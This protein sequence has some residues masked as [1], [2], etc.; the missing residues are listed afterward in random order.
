MT[1]EDAVAAKAELDR[2]VALYREDP[3]FRAMAQSTV[4]LVMGEHGPVDPGRA[5]REAH[6]IALTVAIT[7]LARVYWE[8]AE[9][10]DLR[11]ERDMY[12]QAAEKF[13]NVSP[14]PAFLAPI[15]PGSVRP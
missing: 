4:S 12:K 3:R 7:M 5:D 11:R 14:L 8:D 10:A 13:I 9:I 2:A 15:S 1:Y 6:D